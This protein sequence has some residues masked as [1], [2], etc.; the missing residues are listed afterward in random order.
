[1][2]ASRAHRDCPASMLR[3]HI[4]GLGHTSTEDA[5]VPVYLQNIKKSVHQLHVN[6]HS[7]ILYMH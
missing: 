5:G 1:M 6:P 2:L 7:A 3:L 4:P